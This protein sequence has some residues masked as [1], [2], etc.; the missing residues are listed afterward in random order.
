M[1]TSPHGNRSQFSK[2]MICGNLAQCV[3]YNGRRNC[4]DQACHVAM[5]IQARFKNVGFAT[6]RD[7][8]SSILVMSFRD[9]SA[10]QVSETAHSRPWR[11]WQRGLIPAAKAHSVDTACR[12]VERR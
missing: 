9:D 1:M 7:Q 4:R 2:T 12:R 6:D 10:A 11:T 3:R 8:R 5:D